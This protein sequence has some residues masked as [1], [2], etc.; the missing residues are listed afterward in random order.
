MWKASRRKLKGLLQR[1]RWKRTNKQNGE[2][3]VDSTVN[4]QGHGLSVAVRSSSRRSDADDSFLSFGDLDRPDTNSTGCESICSSVNEFEHEFGHEHELELEHEFEHGNNTLYS[5]DS[6]TQSIS[7]TSP[8]LVAQ[9]SRLEALL[10]NQNMELNHSSCCKNS[11]SHHDSHS[12]YDSENEDDSLANELEQLTKSEEALRNELEQYQ[13]YSQV[14]ISM[15]DDHTESDGNA[16]SELLVTARDESNCSEQPISNDSVAASAM[17][18]MGVLASPDPVTKAAELVESISTVLP[19]SLLQQLQQPQSQSQL[20]G[21]QPTALPLNFPSRTTLIAVFCGAHSDTTWGKLGPPQELSLSSSQ[22]RGQGPIQR[23]YLPSCSTQAELSSSCRAKQEPFQGDGN[24][25][26]T[27]TTM[28]DSAVDGHDESY[29]SESSDSDSMLYSLLQEDDLPTIPEQTPLYL[30][31]TTK[32]V[33]VKGGWDWAWETMPLESDDSVADDYLDDSCLYPYHQQVDETEEAE[34]LQ[35]GAFAALAQAA[36]PAKRVA[37]LGGGEWEMMRKED[38]SLLLLLLADDSD[39][40][41]DQLDIMEIEQ[42]TALVQP[43]P[44]KRVVVLGGGEWEI[45]RDGDFS[46][47]DDSNSSSDQLDNETEKSTVGMDVTAVAQPLPA[48]RAVVLGGGQWKK[49]LEDDL[50]DDSDWSSSSD[51]LNEVAEGLMEAILPLAEAKGHSDDV[52]AFIKTE[53]PKRGHS[54][55][56]SC[57]VIAFITITIL[58]K[59]YVVSVV[60]VTFVSKAQPQDESDAISLQL[61]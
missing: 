32:R 41:S 53:H 58:S 31:S 17:S 49:S 8:E 10:S 29:C 23:S 60:E 1:R 11:D 19:A 51:P 14:S 34:S 44:V 43:V 26:T 22:G 61:L 21:T 16:E 5:A 4:G 54:R 18:R 45:M 38:L 20:I 24:A 7:V 9:V 3:D 2:T 36:V 39:S 15:Q 57:F 37:L 13:S 50:T 6:S 12:Y 52:A 40:S 27:I 56:V 33:T 25:A 59:A 46:L 35:N 48:K 55:I 30:S 42:D 47:N 28:Q